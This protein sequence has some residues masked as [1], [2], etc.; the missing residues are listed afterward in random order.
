VRL[1][2]LSFY[3]RIYT[4]HCTVLYCTQ[5]K[6]III[7]NNNNNNKMVTSAAAAAESFKN[8]G[9]ALFKHGD[10]AGAIEQYKRAVAADPSNPAYWYVSIILHYGVV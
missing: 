9:N 7:I 2:L 1:L 6:R 5:S 3:Y 4:A 8:A 10:F